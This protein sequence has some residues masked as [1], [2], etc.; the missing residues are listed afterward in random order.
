[1]E[2]GFT[3]IG[4]TKL[5]AKVYVKLLELEQAKVGELA[6]ATKVSREQLYPL[7]EKLVERGFLKK[8]NGRPAI[9]HVLKVEELIHLIEEWKKEQIDTLRYVESKLKKL[10]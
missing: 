9:Y 7:L 3:F 10:L 8:T 6:K 4:M 5:E 2:R 1:M